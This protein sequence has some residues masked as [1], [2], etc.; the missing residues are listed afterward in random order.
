M[1]DALSRIMKMYY[2]KE[3]PAKNLANLNPEA[4]WH[5]IQKINNCDTPLPTCIEGVT[6]GKEIVDLWRKHFF[7]FL[8]YV[9]HSS[10]DR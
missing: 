7:D 2:T 5:E 3:A 10:V 1:L 6:A 9:N 8:N 4:F